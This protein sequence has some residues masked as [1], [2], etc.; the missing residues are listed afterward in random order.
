MIPAVHM[1]IFGGLIG[2][3]AALPTPII[4]EHL[5]GAS[6]VDFIATY[7]PEKSG[8]TPQ[9]G[10]L[11]LQFLDPFQIGVVMQDPDLA[12]FNAVFE[13]WTFTWTRTGQQIAGIFPDCR[14][15]Q[16]ETV[17]TFDD[18]RTTVNNNAQRPF[19]PTLL[20]ITNAI[21]TVTAKYTALVTTGQT[22]TRQTSP[23]VASSITVLVDGETNGYP[24]IHVSIIHHIIHLTAIRV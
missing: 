11:L 7:T 21:Y 12:G 6:T 17:E 15:P 13:N 14:V 20:A 8:A 22:T 16:G 19:V 24:S 1:V 3:I 4:L 5:D 18:C 9:G 10:I 2:L 23:S